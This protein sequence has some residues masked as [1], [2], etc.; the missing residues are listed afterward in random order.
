M[1]AHP[2][3][4]RATRRR[5]D[6]RLA[7]ACGIAGVAVLAGAVIAFSGGG[8]PT[9]SG[10]PAAS[11]QGAGAGSAAVASTGA[12]SSLPPSPVAAAAGPAAGS[13]ATFPLALVVPNDDLRNGYTSAQVASLLEGG[14][15]RVPCGLSS[16]AVDGADVA[17]PAACVKTTSIPAVV[18]KTKGSLALLPAGLVDPRVKV[19]TVGGADLFGNTVVRGRAY[20]LT[21]SSDA[22]PAELAGAATVY[23]ANDIRTVVSTGDTCP[24]RSV[25][26]WAVV[27][28]KGWDWTLKGG[29]AR[30]TGTYMDRRFD[31][32]SGNGWPAVTAV[33]TGKGIGAIWSMIHD[34]DLAVNDF[35]CPMVA[36]FTQHESGT[37]FTIDP[38]VAGLMKRVG[39]DVLSLASNHITDLGVRGVS[40]TI[41]FTD[42][43]GV[44]HAGAGANLAAAMKPAV[45]DVRGL[46]FAVLSWDA[47]KQ[48]TPATATTAG[49]LRATSANVKEAVALARKQAD[50]VIAMPQWNWPE[51]SAPFSRVALKQR[52]AWFAAGVDQILGSG[53]HWASAISVTQPDPAKGWRLAVTS[54]GNFLFGQDWSRQTQEGIVYEVTF[55]GRD[56]V[57]VRL[58]PYI[59][60]NG[61]QPSL[62]DGRTDG[63]YVQRQ[64]LSVSDLP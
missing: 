54:H 48:S 50:V 36:G 5:L 43:A 7:V 63:A 39:M 31:G 44:K 13:A 6:P 15:V 3:G 47:T 42:A 19:L 11:R 12:P 35:E 53:T 18:G 34:A 16:I 17:L 20:P 24:D 33:R 4:A 52:D 25:S 22:L 26:L 38:K 32:P 62:T 56:L 30:Y 28:G 64:V 23:D 37:F 45:V 40:Q 21:A 59:V 1:G 8:G 57:Q 29:T 60:M 9:P 27:K 46:K 61:A 2:V 51:Y 10:A 14:K 55:R 41:E 58:H 49:A